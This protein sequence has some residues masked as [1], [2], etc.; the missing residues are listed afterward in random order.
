MAFDLSTLGSYVDEQRLPLIK[1]SVL[2]AKT[3]GLIN[4]QTGVKHSSA[5]NLL[6]ISPIIQ[7]GGCGW[8]AQG[9]AKISQRVLVADNY[10]VNMSLCYKDLLNTF[11][12]FE[13]K[14]GLSQNSTSFDEYITSGVIDGV[15]AKIER[16]IWQG[17]KDNAGEFDGFLTILAEDAITATGTGAYNAIKS[18]YEK[19]PVSILDK[20][21]I[22][23]GAD[24]FRS[25]MLEMVE[26]N[27]YHYSANGADTQEFILPGTNTKVIATNGLNGSNKVVAADPMNLFYGTDML[28]DAETF[29]F[30]YDKT[31]REYRVIVEFN[32]G[33]QVAFPDEVVVGTV[34]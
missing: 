2:G 25:L 1:K 7:E 12:G 33:V 26:K 19:I 15:N 3:I 30:V 32:A 16:S 9:D 10:K 27:L 11:L 4:L 29:E 31:T 14:A 22:F 5:L 24:T 6:D 34:A 8:T 13:V 21:V 28:D 17:D 18:A 23:C 20:A